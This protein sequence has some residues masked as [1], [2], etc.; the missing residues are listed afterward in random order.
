MS[1]I[2]VTRNKK[3]LRSFHTD[4]R[5]GESEVEESDPVRTEFFKKVYGVLKENQLYW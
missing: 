5:Q 3:L 4:G 1:K 2:K